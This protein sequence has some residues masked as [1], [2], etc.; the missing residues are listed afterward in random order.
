ME[1]KLGHDAARINGKY[2]FTTN[3]FRITSNRIRT[4]ITKLL[5]NRGMPLLF[6]ERKQWFSGVV[7]HCTSEYCNLILQL[8]TEAVDDGQSYLKNTL[9]NKQD[10]RGSTP[11]MIEQFGNTVNFA[12]SQYARSEQ[13]VPGFE[14]N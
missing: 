6:S 8:S 13:L 1:V 11:Q 5:S 10:G 7:K 3:G 4:I 9:E 12:S 14:R 2:L